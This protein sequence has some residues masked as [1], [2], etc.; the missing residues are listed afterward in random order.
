MKN[1]SGFRSQVSGFASTFLCGDPRQRAID[2]AE[3][4]GASAWHGGDFELARCVASL[5]GGRLDERFVGIEGGEDEIPHEVGRAELNRVA[6]AG[7]G[8]G[9]AGECF[10]IDG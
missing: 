5:A 9:L 4:I 7:G 6:T 2:R 3:D 8:F 1:L 10:K